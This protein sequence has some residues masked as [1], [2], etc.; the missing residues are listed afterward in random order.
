[1]TMMRNLFFLLLLAAALPAA[2]QK[3]VFAPSAGYSLGTVKSKIIAAR[4]FSPSQLSHG[5]SIGFDLYKF[6][7]VSFK[8]DRFFA[9]DKIEYK[10]GFRHMQLRQNLAKFAVGYG[11]ALEHALIAAQFGFTVGKENM[12][13]YREYPDGTISY[14]MDEAGSGVYESFRALPPMILVTG[15]YIFGNKL[16]AY[17]QIE[18]GFRRSFLNADF[19]DWHFQKEITLAVANGGSSGAYLGANDIAS[20]RFEL[21]IKLIIGKD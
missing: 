4:G 2:A 20:L 21:G 17:A 5:T 3:F 15:G 13:L 12:H 14:G 8:Y 16:C 10:G 6:V 7:A 9:K 1:M 11:G 19:Q 18:K